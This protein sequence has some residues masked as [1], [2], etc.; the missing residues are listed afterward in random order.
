MFICI[1]VNGTCTVCP[2]GSACVNGSSSEDTACLDGYYSA[3]GAASC[4]PCAAGTYQIAPSTHLSSTC[5]PCTAG[6]YCTSPAAAIVGC[7]AGSYSAEGSTFCSLCAA[8]SYNA[9]SNA[10]TCAVSLVPVIEM[11]IFTMHDRD[12][13]PV[14]FDARIYLP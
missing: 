4:I 14:D 11:C 8:G 12:F 5:L 10:V 1:T 7:L 13:F 6:S 9:T 2:A 3:A